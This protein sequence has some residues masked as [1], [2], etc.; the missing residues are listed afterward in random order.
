LGLCNTHRYSFQF[1]LHK[2]TVVFEFHR[3]RGHKMKN[4]L[5][6]GMCNWTIIDIWTQNISNCCKIPDITIKESL[7]PTFCFPL[8]A[9]LHVMGNKVTRNAIANLPSECRLE[10]ATNSSRKEHATLRYSPR[11]EQ[12]S[13]C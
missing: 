1:G 2:V 4:P 12:Y 5:K 9:F 8:W 13:T 10:T 6:F 7:F 11:K 3:H